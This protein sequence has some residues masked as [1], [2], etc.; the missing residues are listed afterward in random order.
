MRRLARLVAIAAIAVAACG[1][2]DSRTLVAAGT[3]LVDS[4]ILDGLASAYEQA[5]AG[6]ELSV[7]GLSTREVLELGSR[8]AAD[9]LITHSP[10]QERDYLSAHPEATEQPLFSSRFLLLGPQEHLELVD[11]LTVTSTL[12]LIASS[13]WE[14]IS[15][16]DG[17]GTYERERELWDAAGVAPWDELW[18]TETGQGMGLSLQVADQRGAFIIVE[19][20]T[21]LA[22]SELLR[23]RPVELVDSGDA[24]SN[25]YTAIIPAADPGAIAFV[26]WLTSPVG[27]AALLEESGR[28]YGSEV[29]G[30]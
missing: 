29:F 16:A 28:I 6:T 4:G 30:P 7:V 13:G 14:F 8:G 3:T 26:G 5:N 22:A 24:L 17:S 11:G 2:G 23:L 19:Q 12:A 10:N 20:G 9:L 1:G 18:Y 27:R 15:R 25:P 21:F